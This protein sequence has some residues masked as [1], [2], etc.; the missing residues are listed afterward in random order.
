MPTVIQMEVKVGHKSGK[1]RKG[2]FFTIKTSIRCFLAK[3]NLFLSQNCHI[4]LF[5]VP[6]VILNTNLPEKVMIWSEI[7][8][9]WPKLVNFWPFLSNFRQNSGKFP[10]F[11]ENST[12]TPYSHRNLRHFWIYNIPHPVEARWRHLIY[13]LL[14]C[15]YWWLF[16]PFSLKYQQNLHFFLD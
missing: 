1:A 9:K 5:G 14:F 12:Y 2:R 6:G 3:I 16:V 8:Q 10:Q 15:A 11:P 7:S 13:G 4:W